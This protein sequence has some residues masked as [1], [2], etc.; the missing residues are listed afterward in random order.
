MKNSLTD[1]KA[2]GAVGRL[3][4]RD[5]DV[6][7]L[8]PAALAYFLIVEAVVGT[9]A[10]WLLTTLGSVDR[11]DW[12]RF[13]AVMFA[14]TVH[15]TIVRRAEEARR[16]ES[17]GPHI[18]L[19]SVWTFAAA[20]ALPGALVVLVTVWMRILVQPIAR[21]QPHRF[22]FSSASILGGT[23]LAWAVV[24]LS[25]L[26]LLATGDV[27]TDLGLVLV[28]IVA[29]VL[30]WSVQGMNI[31]AALKIVTPHT[32]MVEFLGSRADN[33]LELSTLGAGAMLGMLMTTH[34]VGPLL[35]VFPVILVNSLLNKAS[36]RR[37]HLERLVREQ[38]RLQARLT[39]DAH[40]DFR[41]GL[42]NTAGLVE[43]AGRLTDRCARDGQPVTVLAVDLDHFK[44][45]NDTWGHP[46]GN[47]VLA[48][49]GRILRGKLRPGDVAGRDGGEEFVVVLANTGLSEGVL[50]AE[51][52]R[53]AIGGMTVVT[54]D[55]HRNNVALRGRD[56]PYAEGPELRAISASIG[57]AVLPE[58]GD[59]LASGQHSADTALYAAKENGRNQVRVAG[60]DIRPRRLPVPR[61]DEPEITRSA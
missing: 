45:I 35:L 14:L 8:R 30:N 54:T 10:V 43:Y 56:L 44:R 13:G 48:E 22:V 60:L 57:V 27:V 52:I 9:A 12:M 51:R 21:R 36:E 58:N 1:Q 6:W 11:A 19:T 20:I 28:L 34:W 24:H 32:R 37:A 29:A 26:S 23:M 55:K 47:A 49:V 38:E 5:W 15:L 59:S 61:V 41:T 40:T 4:F 46:A 16:D 18:D 17:S 39:E 2:S 31:A 33:M 3:R 53:G 50:I 7:S 42:L 25:G